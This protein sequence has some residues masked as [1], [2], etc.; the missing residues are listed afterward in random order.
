MRRAFVLALLALAAGA[1]GLTG[2]TPSSARAGTPD[3][4]SSLQGAVSVE[5]GALAGAGES[6]APETVRAESVINVDDRSRVQATTTYPNSAIGQLTFTTPEGQFLCT[7]FLVD[8]D[9]VLTSG[10]CLHP[11]GTSAAADWYTG[12]RFSPGQNGAG[13]R[14]F[15]SCGATELWTL[16]GWFDGESEYQDLG[17]IQLDCEVGNQTGWFG[18]FSRPGLRALNE[19]VTHLRGYPGDKPFGT[20]WT[21]RG[22]VWA[23]Q[24]NMAF[25]R[26]DT[27]G[28]QSGSPVF[29]WGRY[30]EGPCAMAV[31]GYGYGH[32]SGP[33]RDNNHGVRITAARES[34]IASIAGQNG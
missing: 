14:P 20:M 27:F 25:Y 31:H 28:G 3:A 33:H 24:V 30:C 23:T 17:I 10:H 34:L 15:G 2:A 21:D 16:P 5:G 19:L 7:G 18:Y 29:Q 1:S 9:T 8:A 26:N 11:G 12:H 22:R 32:G 13:N 6:H 4:V